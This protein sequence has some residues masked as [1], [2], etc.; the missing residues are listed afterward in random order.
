[1]L[2]DMKREQPGAKLADAQFALARSYGVASWP[3]LVLA[4]RTVDAIWL[5]D[6]EA[7][8]ARREAS[9]SAPRDGAGHGVVQLGP[10]DV[11]RGK[12]RP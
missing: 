10:P 6:V 4:C 12:S 2:R 9:E 8:C 5:D 11:V 7:A 3:R 1:L